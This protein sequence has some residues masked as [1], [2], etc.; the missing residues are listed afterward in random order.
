[1]IRSSQVLR[2]M[3]Q[4]SS[5]TLAARRSISSNGD[6][7]RYVISLTGLD[8]DRARR[9]FPDLLS[10]AENRVRPEREKLKPDSSAGRWRREHWWLFAGDAAA[11]TLPRVTQPVFLLPHKSANTGVQAFKSHRAGWSAKRSAPFPSQPTAF[12]DH[13]VSDTRSVKSSRIFDA[14]RYALQ[15]FGSF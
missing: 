13:A 3:R 15:W 2:G 10:I 12:R 6:F 11:C 5:P 7:A 4:E 9:E 1:M 8:L 14:I